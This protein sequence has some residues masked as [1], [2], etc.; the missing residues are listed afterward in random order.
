MVFQQTRLGGGNRLLRLESGRRSVPSDYPYPRG[1]G[2]IR[3]G[4]ALGGS[5]TRDLARHRQCLVLLT[6]PTQ[7]EREWPESGAFGWLEGVQV[8]A[9]AVLCA[10]MFLHYVGMYTL[11]H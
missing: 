6:V 2:G 5:S 7:E 4:C 8:F 9:M 3:I 10:G 11:L 1:K